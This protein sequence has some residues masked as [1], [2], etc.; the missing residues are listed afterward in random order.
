[1]FSRNSVTCVLWL[2]LISSVGAVSMT[3]QQGV[4]GRRIKFNRGSTSASVEGAV[5][6]GTRDTYIVVARRGQTVTVRLSS[7]EDNAVFDIDAPGGKVRLNKT[8]DTTNWK[9]RL[10][11]SGDYRIS[12]GATRGNATYTLAVAIED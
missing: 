11:A 7:L 2:I 10:P 6:R 1:M 8:D 3:A 5:V 9:G 12:I 4:V